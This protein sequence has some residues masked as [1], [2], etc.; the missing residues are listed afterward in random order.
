MPDTTF[1][2]F[3]PP[4]LK[5]PVEVYDTSKTVQ[6]NMEGGGRPSPQNIIDAYK[7]PTAQQQLGQPVKQTDQQ[8]DGDSRYITSTEELA[9]AMGYTSPKEEERLRKA[10]VMNQRILA[11][12]DAL[13]HIANI[14]NT[15]K[16]APSQQFNNPVAEEQARYE[17][18]KAMRD[19]ANQTYLSYQQQK[20]A[21][22]AKMRQLEAQTR[23][24]N[25]S[26]KL[27][28]DEHNRLIGAQKLA[29]Q[30]Q[31]FY[32]KLKQEQFELDKAYNKHKMTWEEYDAK[33]RRISAQ[34]NWIR[35]DKYE[36]GGTGGVG[37]YTTT[38]TTEVHR[39]ELGRETG[40]TKTKT[41]TGNK[42]E[43]TAT[44]TRDLNLKGSENSKDLKLR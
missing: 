14:A 23:Y 26:L 34:A 37:G 9:K 41:R 13:R 27:R 15:V 42:R 33:S 6:E 28:Q 43:T 25:A 17:R 1:N 31:D 4:K 40:R 22:D 5:K 44:Q 30:K 36:P 39:D 19:K 21:Q 32:E 16:G 38:E 18:G 12:G 24:Q 35:A 20:A 11:V 29:Q 3:A 2:L 7:T 10:S 8:V